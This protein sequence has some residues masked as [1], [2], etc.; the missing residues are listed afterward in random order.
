MK[1][2]EKEDRVLKKYDPI[3]RQLGI[4]GNMKDVRNFGRAMYDEGYAD[5]QLMVIDKMNA[6][7][8]K[9]DEVI[10]PNPPFE[11]DI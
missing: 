11:G 5:G 2:K 9:E 8:K 6:V 10:M 3:I 4:G 1:L 7:L